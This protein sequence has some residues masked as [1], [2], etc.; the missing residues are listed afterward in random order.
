M[1]KRLRKYKK[2]QKAEI[3]FLNYSNQF[4]A[5]S[6][7]NLPPPELKKYASKEQWKKIL[8]LREKA[9]KAKKDWQ[10]SK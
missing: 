3:N 10:D 6:E 8:E 5:K 9:D 1:S 4:G 2:Y 7:G